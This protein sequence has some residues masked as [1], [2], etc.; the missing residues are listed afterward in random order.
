VHLDLTSCQVSSLL[1]Q[2]CSLS[3][4]LLRRSAG[5]LLAVCE[6]GSDTH[7]PSSQLSLRSCLCPFTTIRLPNLEAAFGCPKGSITSK[8]CMTCFA[9]QQSS[10]NNGHLFQQEKPGELRWNVVFHSLGQQLQLA[11]LCMCFAVRQFALAHLMFEPDK[12]QHL[13]KC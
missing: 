4:R 11:L 6:L 3:G 1:L 9:G 5:M 2:R 12:R 13:S 7:S 8:L 10:R